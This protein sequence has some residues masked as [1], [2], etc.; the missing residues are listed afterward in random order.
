VIDR[1]YLLNET[2]EAIKYLGEGQARGKLAIRIGETQ[3]TPSGVQT[4]KPLSIA[5]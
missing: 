2:G 1:S 4:K 3:E 5:A